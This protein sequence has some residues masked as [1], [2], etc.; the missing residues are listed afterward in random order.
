MENTREVTGKFVSRFLV[1]EIIIGTISFFLENL[2][3]QWLDLDYGVAIM[4][5]QTV[6]F[7][8]STI[9]IFKLAFTS[10]IGKKKFKKEEATTINKAIRVILIFIAIIIMFF[11]FF[12]C[13]NMYKSA[14]TDIE[15]DIDRKYI[16]L[17]EEDK[18]EA[19]HED[20]SKT[21]KV[22]CIYLVVKEIV[23]IGTYIYV[24][25]YIRSK[26]NRKV[27]E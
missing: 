14:R 17:T 2:I 18:Q 6:L 5:I 25:T 12:Y 20:K 24:G 27:E 22:T 1:F 8:I 11:N 15:N 23:T 19:I 9:L 13:G 4:V 26:L 16:E 21:L 3:P 10:A 7:F